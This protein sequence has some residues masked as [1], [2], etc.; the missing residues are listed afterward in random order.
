MI[1]LSPQRLSRTG[2]GLPAQGR[3]VIPALLRCRHEHVVRREEPARRIEVARMENSNSAARCRI[4]LGFP[5]DDTAEPLIG[6]P[7][8]VERL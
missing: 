4:A 3:N 2:G 6:V 8:G 7:L 5:I 1:G